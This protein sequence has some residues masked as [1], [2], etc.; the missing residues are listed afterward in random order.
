[1]RSFFRYIFFSILAVRILQWLNIIGLVVNIL[2][3]NLKKTSTRWS[4]L[5]LSVTSR[6]KL[7]LYTPD[8]DLLINKDT[9]NDV[10]GGRSTNYEETPPLDVSATPIYPPLTS[11]AIPVKDLVL[12]LAHSVTSIKVFACWQLNYVF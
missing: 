9:P 10:S 2:W 6:K 11:C 8:Q 4:S 12:Q 5:N 1:M 3:K 7:R